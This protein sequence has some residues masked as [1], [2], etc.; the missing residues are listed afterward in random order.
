MKKDGVSLFIF[1]VRR[2]STCKFI[3]YVLQFLLGGFLVLSFLEVREF[4]SYRLSETSDIGRLY[5]Y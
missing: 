3:N 1:I 2:L 5:L 4:A